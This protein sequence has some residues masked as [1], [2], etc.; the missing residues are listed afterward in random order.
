MAPAHPVP[1]LDC[2]RRSFGE[3]AADINAPAWHG[4]APGEFRE[5][6]QGGVPMQGTQVRCVWDDAEFR[7]LFVCADEYVWATMTRRNDPLWEEEVVEAFIDPTGDGKAYFEFEVNPLNAVLDLVLRQNRSGWRKDMSWDC[8][9]LRSAVQ[10]TDTGWNA[11]I[12]I[13]F[14]SIAAEAPKVGAEWRAN[15]CRIDRPMDVPRELTAWSPTLMGTFHEV[16]RF[17]RVRFVG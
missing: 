16:S 3:V 17:G 11:E 4:V 13:P 6:V 1:V 5:S 14:G 7:V 2:P 12:A 10:R 8:E 15:F 9:G